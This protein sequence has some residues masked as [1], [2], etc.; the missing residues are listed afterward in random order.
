MGRILS[1]L[2][3][4][5]CSLLQGTH[6][7]LLVSCLCAGN[8]GGG[9]QGQALGY[10]MAPML[11]CLPCKVACNLVCPKMHVILSATDSG[12][13]RGI[14]APRCPRA[15]ASL[16]AAAPSQHRSA[17]RLCSCHPPRHPGE[18]TVPCPWLAPAC[19][20]SA[21][22][23]FGALCSETGR[24]QSATKSHGSPNNPRGLR[25]MLA[26]PRQGCILAA[27]WATRGEH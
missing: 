4:R 12:A 5:T 19:Q 26:A 25:A 17:P 24:D 21:V 2:Q 18:Q 9:K 20:G 14:R 22:L 27:V 11:V 3:D 23:G 6:A 8:K 15:W 16:Q 1:R 13:A 10:K 7:M